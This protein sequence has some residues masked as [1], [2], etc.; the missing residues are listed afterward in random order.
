MLKDCTQVHVGPK[1]EIHSE[2][3][4]T[5][6]S[7]KEDEERNGMFNSCRQMLEDKYKTYFSYMRSFLWEGKRNDFPLED[8][9]V[10]L[11]VQK[12]DL[13]GKISRNKISLN[14]IF[15]EQLNGHQTILVTGDPGYGKSTLCKKIV[16]DWATT[17][18]LKHFDLTFIVILRELGDRSVNDALFHDMRE[19]TPTDKD[20]NLQDRKRNILVILDGFDEIVEKFKIINFVREKSFYISRRMTIVVTSRPEATED[21]REDMKMRILIEGFSPEYQ[22][23]YIQLMFRD[24]ESKA[25]EFISKREE[26]DFYKEISECPLMLHM[27]CCLHQNGEMDKLETMSDLY[28]RIF[29]LITERYV[30][31]TNQQ[32][33]FERGK[34]FVGEYLL[35]KLGKLYSWAQV[36]TSKQLRN[37]FGKGDAYNFI[38]GLDILTVD[39]FSQCDNTNRYSFV[40]YT[41]GEFLLAFGMYDLSI[42]RIGNFCYM[43]LLFLLGFYKDEPFPEKFFTDVKETMFTPEFMLKIHKQ[44]KLTTNWEQFCSNANL[45]VDS[46]NFSLSLQKLLELYEFKKLYFHFREKKRKY[47][48]SE[49]EVIYSLIDFSIQ[50]NMEINVILSIR[51]W[52][53]ENEYD[54]RATVSQ[55]IDILHEKNTSNFD[56]FLIG[57]VSLSWKTLHES[58]DR[59]VDVNFNLNPSEY[60]QKLSNVSEEEKL[61]ALETGDKLKVSGSYILSL[62]QYETLRDHIILKSASEEMGETESTSEQMRETE[63]TSEQMRET[64]STSEQMRET[65]STSEQMCETKSTSSKCVV[66]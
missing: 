17:N 12:T 22:K 23:K 29:S 44:I 2:E 34:Y 61:V 54:I 55:I 31:K 42:P 46:S 37:E 39:S 1:I 30:R 28:I 5:N 9:Y 38:I 20:W 51:E 26:D 50:Y 32:N 52:S 59:F 58:F 33:K 60:R 15:S 24:D 62:K 13:F 10:E 57:A 36:I 11:T 49:N 64:E 27:L 3:S 21:I 41:F 45:I 66:M 18:Y 63:S 25:N 53:C 35:L 40:H 8:Y 6:S 4:K 47:E 19:Y 16:Y 48:E 56:I 14:E 43:G 7:K 65:E